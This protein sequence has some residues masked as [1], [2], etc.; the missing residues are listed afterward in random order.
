MNKTDRIRKIF[1]Y[2]V[3]PFILFVISSQATFAQNS[4]LDLSTIKGMFV[5]FKDM[6]NLYIKIS[7]GIIIL[8]FAVGTVKTGLAAQITRQ[9]GASSKLST[10]LVNFIAGVLVFIIGILSYP[11]AESMINSIVA[12]SESV[13]GLTLSGVN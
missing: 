13:R 5:I 12:G 9:F 7:Y 8:L 4:M 10:E 6:T 1:S 2:I 11:L 3:T